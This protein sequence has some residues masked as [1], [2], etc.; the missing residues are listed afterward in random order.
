MEIDVVGRRFGELLVE[1]VAKTVGQD[2]VGRGDGTDAPQSEFFAQA[3]LVDGV[4]AFD[5]A[6]GLGRMGGNALDTRLGAGLSKGGSRLLAGQLLFYSGLA[7]GHE[8]RLLV[9]VERLG[10]PV[11][12]YPTPQCTHGGL[13]GLR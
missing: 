6:F 9:R 1:G 11:A 3:V 10:N 8:D 12:L 5:A 2:F 4:V 7:V 13:G